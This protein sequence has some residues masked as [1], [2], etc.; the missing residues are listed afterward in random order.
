MLT[1]QAFDASCAFRGEVDRAEDGTRLPGCSCGLQTFVQ[2]FV[3]HAIKGRAVI[4]ICDVKLFA[5]FQRQVEQQSHQ[6]YIVPA[7]ALRPEAGL[8]VR[9]K[10]ATL[11][12]QVA[13][14]KAACMHGAVV[15]CT[16]TSWDH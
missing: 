10:F 11:V 9:Q 2:K 8:P 15:L 1:V 4:Y 13:L 14:V 5:L 12:S 7:S 6:Q 16:C 3:T